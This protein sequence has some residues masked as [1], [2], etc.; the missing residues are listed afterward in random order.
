MSSW[1]GRDMGGMEAGTLSWIFTCDSGK[2]MRRGK[3][4]RRREKKEG[5]GGGGGRKE[6]E[7][8]RLV[9]F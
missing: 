8:L 6:D 4:R 9:L 7:G 5:G 1:V 3:R 2:N